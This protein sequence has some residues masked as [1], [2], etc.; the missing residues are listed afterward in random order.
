MF[1]VRVSISALML[2]VVLFAL[3]FA[4]LRSGSQ[5]WFSVVYTLTALLLMFAIVASKYGRRAAR[6]F[7]FGFAAFGWGYL[8]LVMIAYRHSTY[9][10]QIDD[11]RA[12]WSLLSSQWVATSLHWFRGDA[13]VAGFD[14]KMR[15]DSDE[16][17]E[18]ARCTAQIAHM[19][20]TL[21]VALFG[22]AIAIVLRGRRERPTNER[23]GP[24]QTATI[25]ALGLAIVA[26]SAIVGAAVVDNAATPAAYFP[27]LLFDEERD[28]HQFIT[29]WYSKHLH[30]MREPS[31]WTLSRSN[32]VATV[33]RL[34]W[35]P[36]F[37]HPAVIRLVKSGDGGTLHLRILEGMGGYEPGQLALDRTIP[38]GPKQWSELELA[39]AGLQFWT[40]PTKLEDDGGSDGDQVILEGV[41]NGH[42][43][44]VDRWEPDD[45]YMDL[46][47]LIV[48]MAQYPSLGKGLAK[49]H[50]EVKKRAR[51]AARN[52][53]RGPGCIAGK[54]VVTMAAEARH[55]KATK[56]LHSTQHHPGNPTHGRL[57]DRDH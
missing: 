32:R 9:G 53:R 47:R 16:I 39:F 11:S 56:Q 14:V 55:P 3:E 4:A 45:S 6:P 49:Y 13:P 52:L 40:M 38:I 23:A 25:A 18:F 19:M 1:K 30:A 10:G 15:R 12:A 48:D 24:S 57:Q 29:E 43:H 50:A 54:A 21:I 44:L 51:R 41:R 7:W 37:D 36:S 17:T 33:Y 20:I 42:Y 46:C 31:L 2:V 5:L 22:G 26:L 8:L 27:D 35:L 34:V 28:H